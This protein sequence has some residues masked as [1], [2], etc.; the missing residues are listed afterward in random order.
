MSE[1]LHTYVTSN[2]VEEYNSTDYLFVPRGKPV[3][4]AVRVHIASSAIRPSSPQRH[5]KIAEALRMASLFHPNHAVSVRLEWN[6][7]HHHRYHGREFF[8]FRVA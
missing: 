6:T 4:G 1:P 8:E 7:A 3:E 5:P 2:V